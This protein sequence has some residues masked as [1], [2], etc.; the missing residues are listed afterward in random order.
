MADQIT[1]LTLLNIAQDIL[2]LVFIFFG[3]IALAKLQPSPPDYT[4]F[5]RK[6]GDLLFLMAGSL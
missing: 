1:Y 4:C 2:V 3:G 6:S 5:G